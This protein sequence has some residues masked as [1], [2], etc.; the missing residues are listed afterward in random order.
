MICPVTDKAAAMGDGNA[1]ICGKAAIVGEMSDKEVYVGIRPEDFILKEDGVLT[2]DLNRVE[3]MG[4]DITVVSAHPD[5]QNVEIRS[6][7]S[8]ENREEVEALME[9]TGTAST[10]RFDVKPHKVHIFSTE[11]GE[12]IYFTAK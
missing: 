4:R 5:C 12:R 2:C 3:V 11:T 7:I 10:V 6:I 9:K 8:S 1:E